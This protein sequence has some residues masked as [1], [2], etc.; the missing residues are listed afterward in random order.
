[1]L[2]PLR[3]TK[4]MVNITAAQHDFKEPFCHSEEQRDEESRGYAKVS[5][6]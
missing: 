1:M 4:A 2:L 6:Q 3:G 5:P